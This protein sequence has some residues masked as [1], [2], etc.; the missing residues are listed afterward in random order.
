MHS[1]PILM[2]FSISDV[3]KMLSDCL[4]NVGPAMMGKDFMA[5]GDCD[6]EPPESC[7]LTDHKKGLC[8]C[9]RVK[10]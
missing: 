10:L 2:F 6:A 8:S 1:V 5:T 3:L 7:R 9:Q 4:S